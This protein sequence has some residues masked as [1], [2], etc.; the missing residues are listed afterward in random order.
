MQVTAE[1]VEQVCRANS[2][3]AGYKYTVI[4][5][6]TT[7]RVLAG[8]M[9]AEY[10]LEFLNRLDRMANNSETWLTADVIAAIE[11][12]CDA[13]M[14]M[15]SEAAKLDKGVP[16]RPGMLDAL[17]KF[18]PAFAVLNPSLIAALEM[19]ARRSRYFRPVDVVST[20]TRL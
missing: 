2:F 8:N 20:E 16:G 3:P 4:I 19:K 10:R 11:P 5:I 9:S 13:G 15:Y 1:Y 6:S 12:M 14:E 18:F 17:A 7:K